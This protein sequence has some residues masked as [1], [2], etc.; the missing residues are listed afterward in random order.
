MQPLQYDIRSYFRKTAKGVEESNGIVTEQFETTGPF[1]LAFVPGSETRTISE[2]GFVRS[3]S[4][5][6]VIAHGCGSQDTS[7]RR[8]VFRAGD[9]LT[10]GKTDLYEIISVKTFPTEQTMNAREI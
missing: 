5:Y 2:Q 9:I 8:G 6:L 4:I 1:S 3:G 10:D 7:D